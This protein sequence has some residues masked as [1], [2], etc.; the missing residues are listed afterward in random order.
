MKKLN[1][2]TANLL[3][4]QEGVRGYLF[5]G[6]F[7]SCLLD[8]KHLLAAAEGQGG[9]QGG[10]TIQKYASMTHCSRATAFRELDQLNQLG[11]LQRVGQGRAV[12]YELNF[13]ENAR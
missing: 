6:R 5:Q 4:I 10:M 7:G 3:Q 13:G 2:G 9:F 1:F 11:I 12:K 8:D